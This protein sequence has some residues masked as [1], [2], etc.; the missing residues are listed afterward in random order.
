M[1]CKSC[2]KEMVLIE[3][4]YDYLTFRC[5]TCGTKINIPKYFYGKGRQEKEPVECETSYEDGEQA[6]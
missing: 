6:S 1:L 2:D 3:E 5:Q 4:R